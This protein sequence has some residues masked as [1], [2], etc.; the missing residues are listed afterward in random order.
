MIKLRDGEIL[1]EAEEVKKLVAILNNILIFE[2]TRYLH[3]CSL[4][5]LMDKVNFMEEEND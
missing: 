3:Q 2:S 4:Q 5:F 1:M